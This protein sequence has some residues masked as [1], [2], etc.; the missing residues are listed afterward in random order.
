MDKHHKIVA[1]HNLKTRPQ[2]AIA[3]YLNT[4]NGQNTYH[5]AR[6][7]PKNQ[8]LRIDGPFTTEEAGRAAANRE[9]ISDNAA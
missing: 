1:L 9:W 4:Y 2:W 7:N 6:V 5:V 8:Y 3:L